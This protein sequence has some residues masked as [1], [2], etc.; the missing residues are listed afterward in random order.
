VK[1]VKMP[2]AAVERYPACRGER[3]RYHVVD[4]TGEHEYE[5]VQDIPDPDRVKRYVI[6][7]ME[8]SR[9]VERSRELEEQ[10]KRRLDQMFNK[11]ASEGTA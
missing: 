3:L 5:S 2:V 6:W 9:R 11:G 8:S 10:R 7:V 1:N 4:E